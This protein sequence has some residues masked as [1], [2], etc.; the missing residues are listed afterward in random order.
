MVFWFTKKLFHYIVICMRDAGMLPI[1]KFLASDGKR[2]RKVGKLL[3]F[4][5]MYERHLIHNVLKVKSSVRV[6]SLANGSNVLSPT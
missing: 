5:A 1:Q 6:F 3:P 2:A 4:S